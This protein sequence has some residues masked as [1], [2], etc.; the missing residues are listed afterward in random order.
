MKIYIE[1][2]ILL[3]LISVILFWKLGLMWLDKKIRKKYNP[4]DNKS[5]KPGGFKPDR[6]GEREPT[7]S[8]TSE[9]VGGS[10]EPERR[11]LLQTPTSNPVRKNSFGIRKILGRRRRK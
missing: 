6:F 11:E 2:I 4:N 7:T 8:N 10:P 1:W 3:A 9:S 5:K